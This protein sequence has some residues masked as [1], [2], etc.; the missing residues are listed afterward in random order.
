MST[1]LPH[2]LGGRSRESG[3]GSGDEALAG[4]IGASEPPQ[5]HGVGQ[6]AGDGR[7][8]G[9]ASWAGDRDLPGVHRL[10]ERVQYRGQAH[11]PGLGVLH[12]RSAADR[13][14]RASAS[15]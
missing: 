7:E 4:V 12:H 11:E 9:D 5:G 3:E 6:G 1:R 2:A 14:D 10:A 15:W 13:D 8:G